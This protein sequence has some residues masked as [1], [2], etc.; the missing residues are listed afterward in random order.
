MKESEM[1]L[2]PNNKCHYF[3]ELDCL[4]GFAILA[5]ITTHANAYFAQMG[6]I[7]NLTILYMVLMVLA[8]YG[9]PLF[10]LVSGFALYNKYR[11][12]FNLKE[13]SLKDS[14]RSFRHM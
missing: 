9:A 3:P 2:I 6:T 10:F 4:R 7:S 5:V 12:K 11:I 13:F 8:D 14:H 1:K